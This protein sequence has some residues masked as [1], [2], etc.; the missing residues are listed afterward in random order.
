MSVK[1]WHKRY[2]SDA[3]TGMLSLSLE[4]RGAYQTILDLIYDRQA[5]IPDNDRLL[6]GYMG[7]SLRKWKV[8]RA[9]LIELGKIT[10]SGGLLSNSRAEK[11]IEN[12][13]KTAR[14]HAENGL[15]G[16]RNRSENQEKCNEYNETDEA[17]LKPGL[18]LRAR[19]RVRVIDSVPNGT[20]AS[21]PLKALFDEGVSL[22]TA[23]GHS[24]QT[25]RSMIGKWR[26]RR[27]DP[28][29]ASLLVTARGKTDPLE[30]LQA[31]MREQSEFDML[32]EQAGRYAH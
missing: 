23:A 27:S 7:C 20:V 2:H 11:E 32:I 6:A 15:K 28:E 22:L 30:Y 14:K 4:E 8:L 17:T 3:L 31:A 1:P 29:L 26:K 24:P 9:R 18:S 13:A 5:P 19:T 12:G 21:D 25:A 10:L 16:A